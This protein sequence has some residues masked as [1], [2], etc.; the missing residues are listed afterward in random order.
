MKPNPI[1]SLAGQTAV[2]GMGT[3]IPRLLNYLLVPFYT[4][5]FAQAEYGQITELY[6]Y[7]AFLL[8]FLTYGMET[9]YF[10]YANKDGSTRVFN[11][12]WS[13]II[14]T[15][16]VFVLAML[17][18]S[19][20]LAHA[21]GY[22]AESSFV[23]LIA[24]IVAMDAVTAVPFARLRQQNKARIFAAIKITNVSVNIGLNLVFL[25]MI[26]EKAAH[27]STLLLG[28]DSGMVLWVF[29]SNLGASLLT[30]LLLIPHCRSFKWQIDF[31]LLKPMLN[32]AIPVLVVGLAGMVNEVMDKLLLKH[33]LPNPDQALAQV[34]IYGANYKLAVLMTLFIQMFRYAAEPFFF[35]NA[36]KTESPRLFARVTNYFVIFGLAIFLLVTLFIDYF[37][38][39]IGPDF[40]EGLS[41][42]PIVLL[43][44]LFYGIF[45]NL[46]VWYKLTDRTRYGAIISLIGASITLFLNI[47][48]IPV[49]GYYGS[50]WAHFVCYFSMMTISYIWGKR[51]YKVP[52]FLLPALGYLVLALALF[53]ITYLTLPMQLMPK[54]IIHSLLFCLF[55]LIAFAIE[56]RRLKTEEN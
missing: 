20:P 13:S 16:S 21:I 53:A 56:H 47:A 2:Y 7:V 49:W 17:F 11:N 6:A 48:L 46:S 41:I 10:R 31:E 35:A 9:A 1:S 14:L 25:V 43:A 40:H 18:A 5:V 27:W 26:P 50:A 3:I 30:L 45:F 54:T 29:V 4:R 42:V 15:S 55:V 39:L 51:F 33:L 12:A 37:K 44:N 8:V 19:R 32:Y 24:L 22:E 52:Y 38:F 34:G 28:P 36:D 23:M